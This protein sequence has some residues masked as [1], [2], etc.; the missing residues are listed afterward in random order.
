MSDVSDLAKEL[1]PKE[2][3]SIRSVQVDEAGNQIISSHVG[4]TMVINSEDEKRLVWKFDLRILPVLAIMYLFNSLDKSNLGNAKTAGLERDLG[5]VGNQYNT[6]LSV[7]F[8][9]YVLTAPFLGIL[10]KKYGPNRVLPIM[11]F[12]FGCMTLL[13]VA[14]QNF[15]G[16]MTLR[17]FLGMAESAFFP[18]VI[19]YQT[20]FYRRGEL[21][22]RLAIFYAAQSIASAFGGLLAYGTFQIEGGP[23]QNWRYLFIIEGS[24]TILFSFFAFWYLPHSASRAR[25]LNEEEKKL[26]FYRMQI[27]S[28]SVV[29]EKFR[30]GDSFQILKHPTS[31]M[32]L[33][34]EICLGVP[35][36]SV[37][38][39]LPPMISRLG[40]G[41]VKTNLY[42]VAPNISGAIM[43]LVLAFL[44]DWT[45]WRFPF[46][47]AGFLF[48]FIGF[49]I[50]AGIDVLTQH[51]VAYFAAFMM[52]WGTSA[53]S[54]LL[55]VWYNNN[56]AHEGR[57]V[58]LT[59]I[60]VP[61][62]NLMG[63]VSSNIFRPQDA[64]DYIPALAT[65]AAFGGTG[66]ALTLILGAWMM[67]DNKRR[68]HQQGVK[69]NVRDIPTERLKDGPAAPEFSFI[70][71]SNGYDRN[72]GPIPHILPS[73]HTLTLDGLVATPAH[74]TITSLQQLPQHTVICALQCAGNRRHTMRT[75]IK[76]VQGLDWFDGAVMNCIFRGPRLSALLRAVG[77]LEELDEERQR[78]HV[79]FAC[80][81]Q[82]C[83]EDAWYG[84]SIPLARALDEGADVILALEM[85]DAA[86]PAKHGGPVR[87]VVP[88]VAGARSVK[89]VDRISVLMVES[90]NFYQ[91]HDYKILPPE[92][93]D[94]ESAAAWWHRTPALQEMPINSVVGVPPN[95]STVKRDTEGMVTVKG[96]ALPSGS[97]GPVVK[98][99]VSA[100]EG[101]SW[102]EA[103]ILEV[104]EEVKVNCVKRASDQLSNTPL[105]FGAK[106]STM[107][108]AD[109]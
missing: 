104:P 99:E 94:A 16:L 46:I 24:A 78:A 60:G 25:F 10:G 47:A 86:L 62:A 61:M 44:S 41:T 67:I 32:I 36:Q 81:S 89:W 6:I 79:A 51:Q 26:A 96:Y 1:P 103:E 12:S 69:L 91:Q 97:N 76:E 58:V 55:D 71:L 88:G 34:I 35:L 93:E 31:W 42:T 28:S 17:W 13:V 2:S 22:R 108:Y 8:I 77:V 90:A 52:T 5:L 100:D 75:S 11:M 74:H 65:T 39:F 85:N 20:T 98:V 63:V 107:K 64:P 83:Q 27:D 23:L 68:D 33:A 38:L 37:Q 105:D 92:V 66:F 109:R 48:T 30:W 3:N 19:Y 43:L 101:E 50:Y 56:I 82:P 73:S 7:F 72:H 18:L 84:A 9:P 59:S 95:G 106:A 40:Y 4:E 15:A 54:V 57:R 21:A 53:P 29:N 14:V 87:V 70:T 80:R 102:V 45:R 49:C